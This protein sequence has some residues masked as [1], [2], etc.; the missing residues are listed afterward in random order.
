M[1][2]RGAIPWE[3]RKNT[4]AVQL[5]VATSIATIPST[6]SPSSLSKDE[7]TIKSSLDLAYKDWKGV[8]YIL[9]G[10]GYAGVDCSSFMQIVFADYFETNLPR[11]TREQ[12]KV[13]SS[14]KKNKIKMGDIV[15]FKTGR[16]TFH[17]GVMVNN[18]QFLH[19]ST[20]SGVMISGLQ[21]RYWSNAYLTTRRIL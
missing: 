2:K 19:A 20:S 1:V 9:G 21:E 10:T 15:F 17:V 8:P 3:E 13:G 4:E 6:S 11:N 18:E 5:P 16:N 14:V 12:M 7:K